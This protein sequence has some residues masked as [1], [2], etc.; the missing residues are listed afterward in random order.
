VTC[1]LLKVSCDLR[2]KC[3]FKHSLVIWCDLCCSGAICGASRPPRKCT[4]SCDNRK[5]YGQLQ[6]QMINSRVQRAFYQ[7]LL[8]RD[9]SEY[10][11]GSPAAD[12]SVS[13]FRTESLGVTGVVTF[14]YEISEIWE[15]VSRFPKN[16]EAFRIF[17]KSRKNLLS[18]FLQRMIKVLFC[19]K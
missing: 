10:L 13:V 14:S 2:E 1:K 7:S 16:S 11:K 12:D 8:T 3:I 18:G 6:A 17:R 15:H 19:E 9:L 5:D 4:V